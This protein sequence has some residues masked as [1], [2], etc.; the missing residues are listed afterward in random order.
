MY[1]MFCIVSSYKSRSVDYI[2]PRC[3]DA[4][5]EF[6]RCDSGQLTF[7]TALTFR[8]NNGQLVNITQYEQ[9]D[10]QYTDYRPIYKASV[11]RGS[12]T[13]IYLYHIDGSWRLGNNYTRSTSALGTVSDSALRPEFITG[14][15]QIHYNGIWRNLNGKLRCTGTCCF[16]C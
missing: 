7:N 14:E 3:V 9:V 12:S 1:F 4:D 13:K 8:T 16:Q 2:R 15:W 6:R 10:G 11:P 5:P